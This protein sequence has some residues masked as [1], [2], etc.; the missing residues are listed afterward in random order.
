MLIPGYRTDELPR[1][2]NPDQGTGGK[3]RRR[4]E[5]FYVE[6]LPL[7]EIN[8][9]GP[10]LYFE[11]RTNNLSTERAVAV[12][13]DQLDVGENFE[14]GYAGRK[15]KNAVTVQRMS[16]EHI[17]PEDL[18]AVEHDRLSVRVLGYHRNKLQP[19]HLAGNR[20]VLKIREFDETIDAE[21]IN[22]QQETL[23][24]TGVPNY[25]GPQRFGLR[26]DSSR[27]GRAMVKDDL[28]DFVDQYLGR[29]TDYEPDECRRARELF[30]RGDYEDA[31]DAWPQT[32]TDKRRA[33]AAWIDTEDPKRALSAISKRKRQLFVSAYQS[34]FFNELLAA[35]M[36]AIDVVREGDIAKKTDTGGMFE[37]QEPEEEQP[38]AR[39]F[40]ISAT[41]LLPGKDPWYAT[42]RP[43]EAEQH[44]LDQHKISEED[45]ERVGYL[46]SDGDRRPFR[47]KTDPEP[48]DYGTDEH[49]PYLKLDFTIPSGCYATVYLREIMGTDPT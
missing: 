9:E 42:A 33:L 20:F 14:I 30:A 7:Y 19:G 10:H 39:Q 46:R 8:N 27:L 35:R 38:R 25:F 5:D 23:A 3:I 24:E 45:F 6:E 40:A 21:T 11:V 37:V 12:L 49:G 13:E 16:L 43:G 22:D 4:N 2:L 31:I 17:D 1:L 48:V 26:R 32:Y 15:D 44:L 47:F 28:E 29:P 34:Q 18:D 36:P 41:G